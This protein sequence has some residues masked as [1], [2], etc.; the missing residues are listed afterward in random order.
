MAFCYTGAR[1]PLVLLHGLGSDH[2]QVRGAFPFDDRA[3]ITPDLPGHGATPGLEGSFGRFAVL[4]LAM[5]DHLGI[6]RF[7]LG[8]IS[9][10]AGISLA[11]ALLA[12][13]RVRR[14]VI[15]RP[16]WL[17]CPALP[18]LRL[19]SELGVRISSEG[20][21]TAGAWLAADA[22]MRSIADRLPHAADSIQ[23]LL[24]RPQ[25]TESAS[26]LPRMVADQP[27]WSLA[28][29]RAIRCPTLV[30]GNDEDPLHPAELART[31][32][33]AI[34]HA[35]YEHLPPRYVQVSDHAIALARLARD[36]LDKD[37]STNRSGPINKEDIPC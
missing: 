35:A 24:T 1:R 16:A 27:F 9:M 11:I 29:L 12:P 15:V 6:D 33:G 2:R 28:D 30:I 22:E 26:M 19:V 7:D 32:A 4:V 21:V 36:F 31:L 13:G 25:A 34:P 5:L 17:D 23:T 14:L 3:L 18:Q 8:G 10:G 37:V 20:L